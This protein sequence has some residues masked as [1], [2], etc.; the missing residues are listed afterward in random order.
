[1]LKD[2]A[3]LLVKQKVFEVDMSFKRIHESDINEVIFAAYL[4]GH[5]K[6]KKPV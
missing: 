4:H 2:Q 1:M 5:G 6:S 3:K